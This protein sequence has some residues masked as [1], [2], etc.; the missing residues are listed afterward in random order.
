MVDTAENWIAILNASRAG[1]LERVRQLLALGT[2]VDSP[3][4][5]SGYTP[6]HNAISSGNVAL[7]ELLLDAGA[8]IEHSENTVYI[9]PLSTAVFSHRTEMVRVLLDRGADPNVGV[10]PD[11]KPLIDAARTESTTAIVNLLVTHSRPA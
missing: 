6:L 11:G 4:I 7:V 3:D 9:T 1:D 2:S 8:N 5:L 10:Y